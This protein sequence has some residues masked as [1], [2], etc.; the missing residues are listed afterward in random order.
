MLQSFNENLGDLLKDLR[1]YDGEPFPGLGFYR[2][3]KYLERVCDAAVLTASK[4]PGPAQADFAKLRLGG[5]TPGAV[6]TDVAGLVDIRGEAKTFEGVADLEQEK[7]AYAIAE[8]SRIFPGVTTLRDLGKVTMEFGQQVNSLVRATVTEQM[9]A[10]N[11]A[12][13]FQAVAN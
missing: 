2:S 9:A 12:P 6:Q 8:M 10:A 11:E 3:S 13:Y 4:L 5:K 1:H 7:Q